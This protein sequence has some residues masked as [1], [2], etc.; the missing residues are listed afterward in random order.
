MARIFIT[1]SA[2]GLGEFAA[3]ALIDQGHKVVLHARNTERAKVAMTKVPAAEKVLIADLSSI[4]ETRKLASEVN[5]MGRFDAVIHNAG[6]Y[7]GSSLTTDGL[8][9]LFQVN[10]LAPYILT[11]LIHKPKRLIYMSS[12]M[13]K[14]GS[15]SVKQI[16]NIYSRRSSVSYSDTKLHD[17]M[18][19]FAIARKWPDVYSN[20]VN[21]G[22][23]PTKMGGAGAPD[24]IEQGIETQMW[25]AVSNDEKAKV[26]GKYFHHKK[27]SSY[28]PEADEVDAQEKLLEVC[29]ELSGVDFQK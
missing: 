17:L 20:A 11:F 14:Q 3:K 21:P 26:T 15:A 7:T 13:H 29:A 25:L 6:I 10:T 19:A 9:V 24:S 23:V 16:E 18:L 27:Q 28:L 22:W 12:G 2:D 1:G 5:E 8:P 4:Q